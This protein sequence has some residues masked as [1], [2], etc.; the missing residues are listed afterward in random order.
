MQNLPFAFDETTIPAIVQV[1]AVVAVAFVVQH[2]V[3]KLVERFLGRTGAGETTLFANLA[4][5]IVWIVAIA[6][7]CESVFN[8]KLTS[9][10]AALGVG[11]LILS[12]GLQDFIKNIVAGMDII[13]NKVYSVGDQIE[14][15]GHRG[16]V[17]DI[18]WRQT[19]IRDGNG[20]PHMIPNSL[21]N[22]QVIIRRDGHTAFRHDLSVEL[23]PGLDLDAVGA[24]L[25]ELAATVLDE[26][27]YQ[28]SDRP[29]PKVRFLGA[30][31]FGIKTTVSLFIDDIEHQVAA[32]DAVMRA[33]NATGY[34]SDYM[35]R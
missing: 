25:E 2:A 7:I 9:V 12:L 22:T 11:S 3:V 18:T 1:V 31:A 23:R 34:L 19:I 6:V 21:A 5:S 10:V 30:S 24:E 15:A 16:E 26:R 28:A 29:T 8:V 17:V 32:F 27:G 14:I 20:N 33:F 35:Y 13:S 4:R